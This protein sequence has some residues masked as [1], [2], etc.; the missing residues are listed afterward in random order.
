M[1]EKLKVFRIALVQRNEAFS[2]VQFID[3]I[4]DVFG[5]IAFIRKECTFCQRKEGMGAG[6]DIKG[7]RN[8]RHLGGGSHFVNGKA[9]DTVYKDM[10]FIAP[11]KCS[12][13][14]IGSVGGR[15]NAK[16]AVLICFWLIIL[17]KFIGEE[18]LRVIL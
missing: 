17:L 15:I 13:F 18:R 6:K 16:P 1:R 3:L 9:G 11:V 8:V 10:V 14:F 12:L 4:V 2:V 5:I 7:N